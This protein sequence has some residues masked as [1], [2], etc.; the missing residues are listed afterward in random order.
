MF[1]SP[2]LHAT[3]FPI[4]GKAWTNSFQPIDP[5]L[6]VLFGCRNHSTIEDRGQYF[7]HIVLPHSESRFSASSQSDFAAKNLHNRLGFL[8]P[9][10]PIDLGR[11]KISY[12]TRGIPYVCFLAAKRKENHFFLIFV[13]I[14]FGMYAI[15]AQC[16]VVLCKTALSNTDLPPLERKRFVHAEIRA[17]TFLYSHTQS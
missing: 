6:C 4:K 11:V 15:D 3:R 17:S 7:E 12:L 16:T 5:F 13:S 1:P 9:Q 2:I 10:P 14:S 8:I